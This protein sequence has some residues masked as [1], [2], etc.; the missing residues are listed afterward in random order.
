MTFEDMVKFYYFLTFI[1]KLPILAPRANKSG[2]FTIFGDISAI[3]EDFLNEMEKR[4]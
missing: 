2:F 3:L 4:E 1:T